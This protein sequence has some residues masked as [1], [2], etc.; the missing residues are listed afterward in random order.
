MQ[1]PEN[2]I[3]VQK[4]V[5]HARLRV[6]ENGQVRVIIPETFGQHEVDLLLAKK[7]RWIEK[8]L[9]YFRN[10]S[11]IRLQRNQL[12]LFGNR[13][14]YF[15][16]DSFERKI[17]VDHTHKTIRARRDL[18]NQRIQ[19]SW[20]K[21]LAKQHLTQ[22]TEELARNL[23]FNYNALFI[24]NQR[25]KWGNCSADKNI[26]YNWRLIKAPEFVIDYLIVHELIHTQIMNH[27]GRFW[28]ML[29]SLYPDYRDAINW[30]DTYGNS[31]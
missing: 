1:V 4:G 10:K 18:L 7:K 12:L 6:S 19:E 17:T 2:Y 25:T 20:Y 9:R 21:A 28:T 13:Y 15:Y 27:T 31:L 3:V 26:S 30:L 11:V 16:D 23:N 5:K 14:S 24:R 29:R 22:R 8:H